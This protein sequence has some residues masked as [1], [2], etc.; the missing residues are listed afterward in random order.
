[1]ISAS[2]HIN[3]KDRFG[4]VK[5]VNHRTNSLFAVSGLAVD[6]EVER[7]RQT[8]VVAESMGE[9]ADLDARARWE[10]KNRQ[11]KALRW[12]VSVAGWSQD[13]IIW[14]PSYLVQVNAPI[15]GL[16]EKLLITGVDFTLSD[17][18]G[19][20]TNLSLALPSC[21]DKAPLSDKN[22]VQL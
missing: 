21:Y 10:V 22:L 9:F 6:W 14:Q 1:M 19:S 3:N 11:A 2:R 5:V 18:G 4:S 7:Y 8:L 16:A 15:F 20:Q 17:K 13:G 12:D